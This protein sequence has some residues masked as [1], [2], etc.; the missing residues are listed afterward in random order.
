MSFETNKVIND[1]CEIELAKPEY[2]E[3]FDLIYTDPPYGMKYV[4]NIPGD[5]ELVFWGVASQG[6]I[7]L[8]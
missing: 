3:A 6:L 8:S 2:K 7:N 4:S 1:R 5:D